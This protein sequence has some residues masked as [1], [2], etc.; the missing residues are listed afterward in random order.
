MIKTTIAGRESLFCVEGYS[1]GRDYIAIEPVKDEIS[2][3][4]GNNSH[5]AM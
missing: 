4:S 5:Q 1:I 2:L 3:I